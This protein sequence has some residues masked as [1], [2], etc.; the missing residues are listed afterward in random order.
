MCGPEPILPPPW[1]THDL[2]WV[3]ENGEGQRLGLGVREYAPTPPGRDL[4]ARPL[5]LAR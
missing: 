3:E 5:P 4:V 1:P 2:A